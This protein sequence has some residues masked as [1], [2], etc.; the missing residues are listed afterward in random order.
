MD[1]L[2]D[3]VT[4]NNLSSAL[5]TIA[6]ILALIF[7]VVS[8]YKNLSDSKKIYEFLLNS[9]TKTDYTFRSTQVISSNTKIAESRVEELCIKHPK[10]KRNENEKQSWRIIE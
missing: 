1:K 6:I 2:L 7:W 8:K 9:A 4:N 5:S 3:F 10:I